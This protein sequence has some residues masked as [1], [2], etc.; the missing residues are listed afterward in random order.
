MHRNMK[1][2]SVRTDQTEYLIYIEQP[3]Y[4]RGNEPDAQ[5]VL[6]PYQLQT[7]ILWLQEAK[8]EFEALEQKR[9]AEPK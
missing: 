1:H 2:L 7:L 6:G 4:D 8:E 9:S 3:S 5:M